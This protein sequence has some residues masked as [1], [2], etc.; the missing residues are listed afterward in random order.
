M[1]G[2]GENEKRGKKIERKEKGLEH[3]RCKLPE[4]LKLGN[5]FQ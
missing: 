2:N 1:N 4:N 5:Y 3:K